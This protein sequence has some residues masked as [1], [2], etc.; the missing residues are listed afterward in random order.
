MY[1][2]DY[3]SK[4]NDP[5]YLV[6]KHKADKKYRE[7]LK[8]MGILK[9]KQQ[10]AWRKWISNPE[11]R[12][13]RNEK[14]RLFHLMNKDNPKYKERNRNFQKSSRLKIK[15]EAFNQYSPNGV[16]KCAKCGFSDIRALGLDHINNDGIAHKKT[17]NPRNP[18][19]VT[20]TLVYRDLKKKGWPTGFQI[21]CYNC[22]W[23]K[24]IE[25]L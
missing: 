9:N 11:N 7:K 22:N 2:L 25:T 3:E 16:I 5:K 10:D 13:K 1:K 24:Y 18:R 19:R 4:K 17:I 14:S 21:L 8:D 23:I 6:M 15:L 20:G 12:D